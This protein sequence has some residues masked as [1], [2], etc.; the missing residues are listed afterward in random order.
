MLGESHVAHACSRGV[1]DRFVPFHR[2][3]V[4]TVKKS[5]GSCNLLMT[6]V[7]KAVK[8]KQKELNLHQLQ[9]V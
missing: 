9:N 1:Q 5:A 7:V 3:A 6:D 8:I 2:T 4:D